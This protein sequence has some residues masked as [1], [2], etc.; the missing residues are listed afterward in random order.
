MMSYKSNRGMVL[1]FALWVL[2]VL[3]ILA[4]SVAAGI[5]QKIFLVARL[6]ERS[7]MEYLLQATVKKT[8]GYIHM[9][10]EVS[11]F[12]FTSAVKMNL[13]NN[14]KELTQINLGHDIA[15]V[16]YLL[17][18][19]KTLR[20]GVVDEESK[21][22]LNKTD[23]L[24]LTNLLTDVLGLNDQDASKLARSLLDWRINGE[25]ELVGFY[26]E[27]YYP[28]LQYPYPKK[29]A[30]YETL[31]EI[32][33]VKGVDK[34][35]YDKIINY[36]TIYGSGA[37]NVNTASKEVLEALGMTDALVEKILTVR[38]GRDQ[39]D[40][41]S[42]DQVFLKPYEIAVDVNGVVPLTLDESR[43]IDALN[44]KGLLGT[45]SFYYTIEATGTLAGRSNTGV[46]RAVYSARDDKIVYWKE[47]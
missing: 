32:L 26:S 14:P 21:L 16:G 5:R 13:L 37:V 23:E 22:N 41:T 6:D 18:D 47:R 8:A 38:R 25:S 40:A 17:E 19:G 28:N 4:V 27:D 15:G 46:V 20:W 45:N 3:T 39:V 36:V 44:A 24:T 9:Q 34:Q 12:E 35:I 1:F 11:T 30:N 42:D 43:L 2:G 10:M 33:L 7:R 29:S 31:D